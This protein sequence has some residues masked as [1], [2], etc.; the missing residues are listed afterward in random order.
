MS[1]FQYTGIRFLGPGLEECT[2]SKQ[3]YVDCCMHHYGKQKYHYRINNGCLTTGV[4]F[5]NHLMET[6]IP[7][8]VYNGNHRSNINI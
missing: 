1:F 8:T 7:N 4:S 5:E 6:Y 2:T 3:S